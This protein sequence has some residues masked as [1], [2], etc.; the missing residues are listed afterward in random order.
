MGCSFPIKLDLEF[1][2]FV[3]ERASLLFK[4][5][6]F[7]PLGAISAR[8]GIDLRLITKE[9]RSISRLLGEDICTEELFSFSRLLPLSH[10]G[11][12]R[13]ERSHFTPRHVRSLSRGRRLLSQ[14]PVSGARAA[15][16]RMRI[17]APALIVNAPVSPMAR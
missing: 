15:I 6:F 3:C 12:C 10:L 2:D 9:L 8:L 17:N 4:V 1:A 13:R 7:G 16:S 14:E 11:P 5:D